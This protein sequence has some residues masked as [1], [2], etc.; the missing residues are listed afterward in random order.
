[1]RPIVD[2]A[3]SDIAGN[4]PE[5]VKFA[6]TF[7]C[8]SMQGMTR[9]PKINGK[10][11][12]PQLSPVLDSAT[13]WMFQGLKKCGYTRLQCAVL[14]ARAHTSQVDA[15]FSLVGEIKKCLPNADS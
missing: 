8:T 2:A 15:G 9:V 13:E 3:L 1:M 6:H 7:V 5:S 14:R 4:N 12:V 10:F 11:G